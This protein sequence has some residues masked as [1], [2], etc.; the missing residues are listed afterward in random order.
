MTDRS[1]FRHRT[2]AA[3]FSGLFLAA[4]AG[5]AQDAADP[6]AAAKA[7]YHARKSDEARAAFTAL[8]QSEPQNGEVQYYLGLLAFRADDPKAAAEFLEHAVKLAPQAC[9]YHQRLGDAYGMQAQRASIFSKLGLAK[10]C[11]HAY[12]D[13]VAADGTNVGARW[14]LMEF[15]K[16][17]PGFLDGGMDHAQTQADE[18]ARLDPGVGRWANA[19]LRLKEENVD[20]AL[21]LYAGT[22]SA[23]PPDYA[24]LYQ[25]GRITEWTGHDLERGKQALTRCLALEPTAWAGAHKEVQLALGHINEKLN[26]KEAARAAYQAALKLDP[27]FQPALD[28]LAK[29][30]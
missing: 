14:S 8:A 10:K 13:A 17:A 2:I 16:E 7:L 11:L 3:L 29:L 1:F 12:E 19:L 18:I 21:A 28:A 26:D 27:Q 23:E 5:H 24:A 9:E 15:Y 6:V 30:G 20:G 4:L 22:L 25:L